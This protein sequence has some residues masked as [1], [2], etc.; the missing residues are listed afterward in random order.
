MLDS[1]C[2]LI[3]NIYS[4]KRTKSASVTVLKKCSNSDNYELAQ[5]LFECHAIH[6]NYEWIVFDIL[7]SETLQKQCPQED[8]TLNL[9]AVVFLSHTFS[10][11][12]F[13]KKHQQIHSLRVCKTY[14]QDYLAVTNF[15]KN[16][17]T[18]LKNLIP[19]YVL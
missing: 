7:Q 5:N 12:K 3:S 9:Y 4:N 11:L 13:I 14:Q 17:Q 10:L 6:Y 8:A 19:T 15:D 16:F 18:I 2:L 1:H